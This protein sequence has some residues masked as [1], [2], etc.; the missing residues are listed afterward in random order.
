MAHQYAIQG[1]PT[2]DMLAG[3]RSQLLGESSH[4]GSSNTLAWL[5]AFVSEVKHILAVDGC[6][7]VFVSV[8]MYV[9]MCVWWGWRSECV[10][11][12]GGVGDGGDVEWGG[13]AGG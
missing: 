12:R 10:W 6:L 9:C 7:H 3:L 2:A 13:A 5:Q 4:G 8:S 11:V 1:F